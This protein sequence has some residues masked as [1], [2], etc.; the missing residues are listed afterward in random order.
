M[1]AFDRTPEMNSKRAAANFENIFKAATIGI[2]IV[3]AD[4]SINNLNRYAEKLFGY[5]KSELLGQPIEILI[6]SATSHHHIDARKAF[7]QHPAARPMGMGRELQ[8]LKKNGEIFPVEIGLSPFTEDGETFV[9]AFVADITQRKLQESLV[10]EQA[11]ELERFSKRVRELNNALRQEATARDQLLNQAETELQKKE[12]ELNQSFQKELHLIELKSRFVTMASHEFRT[13]LTTISS[14]VSLIARHDGA[15]DSDKRA[16]HIKRIKQAVVDMKDIL[17]DFLSMSRLEEGHIELHEEIMSPDILETQLNEV[18]AEMQRL[19]KPGQV[20]SYQTDVQNHVTLD[21]NML[22]HVLTNLISNAIK[23]SPEQT[24]IVVECKRPLN[25]FIM[26]IEDHGIG[27]SESDQ[28]HL[29]ERFFR[30]KNA[31]NIQGTGLGLHIVKS[32]VELSG[33]HLQ[34]ASK[35]N[36]GTKITIQIPQIPPVC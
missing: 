36:E 35:L 14:S 18:V 8:A 24:Q 6:P 27:I 32:Y 13:P 30:A 2:I 12:S 15:D 31:S 5:R 4:G 28:P 20:I 7:L 16:K 11:R 26:T 3:D 29:F 19:A 1:V 25:E 33:G 22:R 21:R 9:I 34:V 23:F 10:Q 17:D